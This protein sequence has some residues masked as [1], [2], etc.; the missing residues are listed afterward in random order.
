[1]VKGIKSKKGGAV[2]RNLALR[3]VQM[4]R[5]RKRGVLRLAA[6]FCFESD[7]QV[8]EEGEVD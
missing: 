4:F 2:A 5:G 1:V 8:I 6:Q 7:Q 3:L